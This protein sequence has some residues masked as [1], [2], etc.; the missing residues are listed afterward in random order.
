MKDFHF[1]LA[2]IFANEDWLKERNVTL[3]HER[4]ERLA[5]TFPPL[6]LRVK[7][8]LVIVSRSLGSI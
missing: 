6:I 1:I 5:T 7:C 8:T 3:R 4:D 2:L